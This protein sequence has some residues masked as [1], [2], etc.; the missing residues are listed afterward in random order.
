MAENQMS[1]SIGNPRCNHQSEANRSRRKD[2]AMT[3][4]GANML[5]YDKARRIEL[6]MA[7]L[8][9]LPGSCSSNS[10]GRRLVK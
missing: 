8:L 10:S 5:T 9:E 7:K 1:K 3:S 6:N 2:S 4:M